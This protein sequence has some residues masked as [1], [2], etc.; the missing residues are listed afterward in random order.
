[1]M[2][3]IR[4]DCTCKHVCFFTRTELC[5]TVSIRLWGQLICYRVGLAEIA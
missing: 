4:V 3:D 2:S 1:M 5:L